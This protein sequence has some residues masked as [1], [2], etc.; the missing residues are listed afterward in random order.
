MCCSLLFGGCSEWLDVKP[1]DQISE[2][3][4]MESEEGFQKLLNG[5]YIELNDDDLYGNALTVEMIEIMGGAYEI[6]ND[7]NTWSNYPD[8]KNYKYTTEY[9]RQRLDATWDKAYALVLNCNKLLQNID[10]RKELFPGE[11]YNIIKG[12]ALALR[13]LLHFDLLRLF[14]PV[15]SLRPEALSIPYY[16]AETLTPEP[17]LP[18]SEV[19]A[20]VTA[21]LKEARILLAND[22]VITEG[23]LMSGTSDGKSNFLRYRALRLNYY[24]VTGLLARV[25]LYA[26]QGRDAYAYATEVIKAANNGIFPF[27]K[28]SDVSGAT[29]D[30]DRIFSTEVLFALSHTSRNQLFKNYFDPARVPDFTFKME[31]NLMNQLIYGGGIETGGNQDDYRCR[32]NWIASGSA[33]YFYKYA[34]LEETG[35]IENT[36]IPLLRLGEM[37]LI[38][39]EGQSDN[40]VAGVSFVNTLRKNRGV[41]NLPTLTPDLLKYEYIRE[42]YGEGQLFFMYKR[43]YSSILWSA[44]DSKNPQPAESVFV[45]PLPDTEK[46][47]R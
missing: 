5:I 11:H 47:D 40:L 24:A 39:A 1:Y 41:S 43:L 36:M 46:D 45:V 26:G 16:T 34:D 18:A 8:L 3:E 20:K 22:P 10:S 6:G 44:S 7:A 27:V 14:G 15:Y 25:C 19:I 4:L 32:V 21:D 17:L 2:D 28:K 37:Y 33:R 30:P 13:A 12:E 35:K 29:G 23:T 42:L 38:A 31:T 9:W